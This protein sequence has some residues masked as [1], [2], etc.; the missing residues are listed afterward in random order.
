MKPTDGANQLD[1]PLLAAPAA[2]SG[3][4]L[5]HLLLAAALS[6]LALG[7]VVAFTYEPEVFVLLREMNLG[8]LGAALGLVALRVLLNGVRLMYIARGSLSLRGGVRGGVVWD[9]LSAVTPSSLGGG[10]FAGI[11]LA[12]DNRLPVGETTAIMLFAMLADQLWLAVSIPLLL[13]AALH[14]EV[15]PPALGSI[16]AGVFV[17]AVG[18][19]AAWAVFLAY[20]TLLRPGVVAAVAA[21]LARLRPL[22]RFQA[23][24]RRGLVSMR[25]QN[26][27]LRGQPP[28]FY[29][30]TFALTMALWLTRYAQLLAVALAL[31]PM[32][33]VLTALFRT[34]AM[35]LVG[36]VIP[37]PGGSGGVEGLF[38][39]FLG[40][41][42][43]AAAVAPALLLWRL[44]TYH[45]FLIAGF[46]IVV[47]HVGVRRRGA[48]EYPRGH[49]K[50]VARV[51]R[52]R[53]AA[54]AGRRSGE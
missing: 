53:S 36:L 42:M 16:G 27:V 2:A 3:P 19:I 33:D 11:F 54:G 24:L 18:L 41:L 30:V 15:L 46:L 21:R 28:Q 22:Q 47:G 8:F 7:A 45:L 14:F 34:A 50:A 20:A 31:Y 5:R 35:L 25:Q 12:R 38:V 9:F 48:K 51:R 32:L 26:R 37:T 6:L 43:P 52:Q 23:R 4:S 44:L 40:P 10:P 13:L 17:V 1:E 39:L 29:I 49:R